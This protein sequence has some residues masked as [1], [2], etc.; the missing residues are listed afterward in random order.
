MWKSSAGRRSR[1]GSGSIGTYRDHSRR[2]AAGRRRYPPPCAARSPTRPCRLGPGRYRRRGPRRPPS[3]SPCPSGSG[4]PP[5]SAVEAALRGRPRRHPPGPS[6]VLVWAIV[7]AVVAPFFDAVVEQ[8]VR[9][10][11]GRGRRGLARG[12]GAD[13]RLRRA[14]GPA[15][16][17]CSPGRLPERLQRRSLGPGCPRRSAR[18]ERR[19][20][21]GR[22]SRRPHTMAP[23]E[24]HT[25][26]SA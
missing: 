6:S 8:G 12:R 1:K 10:G 18:A 21:S 9:C 5:A 7:G 23:E 11:L 24:T 22:G 25:R 3:V 14:C 19:Q 26:R 13:G 15:R 17:G 20:Q 2:A 16:L 4:S